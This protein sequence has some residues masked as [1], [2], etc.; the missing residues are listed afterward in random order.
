MSHIRRTIA[1]LGTLVVTSVLGAVLPTVV[2]PPAGAYIACGY[3]TTWNANTPI[4]DN[5]TVTSTN[6]QSNLTANDPLYDLDVAINVSHTFVEDLIVKLSYG[7]HTVE[8]V[9]RRG[10]SGDNFT[11]TRFND[12]AVNHISSGSAPFTGQFRPEQSLNAFDDLSPGGVWTLS[13]TDAAGSDVGTLHSW[14]LIFRTRWCD[15]FDRDDVKD[16]D[17]LCSDVKGVAPHGCPIRGRTVSISYN[18]TA[19]EF[20]GILR[21]T[22]A[23]RCADVEPVRIYK[24]QAGADALISRTYTNATGNYAV[25]K[26]SVGGTYYAVAPK[27]VEE[28]VA[29]CRRAQ[30]GNLTL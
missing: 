6:D 3:S 2:A 17:D 21:C 25:P 9:R 8:L 20:R 26:L 24:V 23:P 4:P 29:E 1:A 7:G 13:V 28:G 11:S 22:A 15:D 30:S 10:G 14:T 18:Q 12:G 19:K 5:G 16:N 27:V